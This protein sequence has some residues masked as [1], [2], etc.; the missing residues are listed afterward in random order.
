MA[1]P[2]SALSATASLV[3]ELDTNLVLQDTIERIYVGNEYGDIERGIYIIRGENVVLLGEL[4]PRDEQSNHLV[5]VPVDVILEK[6]QVELE[7]KQ[8]LEQ[9]RQ[10]LLLSQGFQPDSNEMHG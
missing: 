9:E 4:D 3:D 2:S 8:Q 7:R 5:E 1:L 6:Q 10:Q